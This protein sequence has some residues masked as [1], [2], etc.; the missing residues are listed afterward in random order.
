M[1]LQSSS[2]IYETQ[3]AWTRRAEEE[4]KGREGKVILWLLRRK[5]CH[6]V[7]IRTTVFQQLLIRIPG[8][9]LPRANDAKN[10][11]ST[12]PRWPLWF[13]PPCTESPWPLGNPP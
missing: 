3:N 4:N 11:N 7:L 8:K 12:R 9:G 13:L 1:I 5:G 10:V 2:Y 6:E